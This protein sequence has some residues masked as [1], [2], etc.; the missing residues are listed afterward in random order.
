[1]L[2]I[3]DALILGAD[4]HASWPGHHV[5]WYRLLNG[6]H[7]GDVIYVAEH[8]KRLARAGRVV[9][10]GQRIAI[11]LPG[12]PWTEWGWAT[13]YGSPRAMPCYKE[14]HKTNSGKEMARFLGALGAP[15]GDAPGHG[16]SFPSGRRC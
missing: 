2:A 13:A 12:Y 9:H 11:A 10:A 3:G 16:S 6:S 15:F 14:G 7:R 8:L 5:I 4:N 1:V